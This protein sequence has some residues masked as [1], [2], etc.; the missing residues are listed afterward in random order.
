V[1]GSAPA[2]FWALGPSARA[3]SWA[4]KAPSRGLRR[5]LSFR[6][7]GEEPLACFS[8]SSAARSRASR[9]SSSCVCVVT[10]CFLGGSAR[11][12]MHD[13]RAGRL[14]LVH[15]LVEGVEVAVELEQ[16]VELRHEVLRDGPAR[17]SD[18]GS[19]ASAGRPT[20]EGGCWA[21]SLASTR[22]RGSPWLGMM[23]R[24]NGS[25]RAHYVRQV[26]ARRWYAGLLQITLMGA[27]MNVFKG[28]TAPTQA[29]SGRADAF[30]G[31]EG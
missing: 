27:G 25:R 18:R 2:V 29:D 16:A 3:G 5:W 19:Y 28:S 14:L 31:E 30:Q 9:A 12:S 23:G 1:S 11:C 4:G 21:S 8:R 13:R 15:V 17:K 20:I 7:G 24:K 26:G 10:A 6:R 22:G